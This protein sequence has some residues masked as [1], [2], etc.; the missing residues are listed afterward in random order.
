MKEDSQHP[1]AA[2]DLLQETAMDCNLSEAIPH[3]ALAQAL[4]PTL[5]QSLL[6]SN[7][8][9]LSTS[10]TSPKTRRAI[11]VAESLT[12]GKAGQLKILSNVEMK[13]WENIVW[14]RL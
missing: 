10:V 4:L 2:V 9:K 8:R 1:N 11:P 6:L 14:I 3:T 5:V 12:E 13:L 7:K